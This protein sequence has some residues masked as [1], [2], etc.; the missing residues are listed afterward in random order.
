[1]IAV[2][3]A[4]FLPSMQ[5]DFLWD[6]RFFVSENP[7]LL[8]PHFLQRFLT[9]PFGG[10]S[11]LDEN[12]VQLDRAIQFY[13]PL[14]SLSN[15]IDLKIWGLNPAGFHL[16][17]I[18]IQILN[19]LLLY[20]VLFELGVGQ[21][22]SLLSALLFSVFPLHFENVSWI[23]GR[24]DLLSFLFAALSI[25]AFF[26][27]FKQRKNSVLLWSSFFYLC[28]LMAKETNLFLPVIY[29]L[30]LYRKEP[31]VKSAIR[32]V[33]PFLA[34]LLTWFIL[35][36]IAL[37]SPSL[38]YSGRTVL[39]FLAAIGFYT[40]K[41]VFPFDLSVTVEAYHI[42]NRVGFQ[43][44]GG[45]MTLAFML[46]TALILKRSTKL[47]LATFLIFAFYVL[48]LPSAAVIFSS[49]TISLMAWRFLYLLSAL[50]VSA[51]VFLA[52]T[53]INWKT[54]AIGGLG[55]LAVFY[56]LEIYPKNRLY[57]HNE[58]DFWMGI[59]DVG[60]EDIIARSNIGIKYLDR[61]ER[62]SLEIL[63]AILAEKDH[64]LHRM[65]EIRIYEELAEYYTLKRDFAK[66]EE[67]FNLLFK[68][69]RYQS[70][71]CYFNYADF[72]ALTDK[73][74][75]GE[76]IVQEMITMFPSNHL[77]LNYAVRF[78]LLVKD[79][80]KAV[81]YVKKDSALFPNKKTSRLLREIEELEKK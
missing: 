37:G 33:S 52:L 61:D 69:Q 58:T 60:R 65:W 68:L 2:N 54:A 23:S 51:L 32:L 80:P 7:S 6:D 22:V 34:G 59:K 36:R 74:Q 19:C 9:S 11:G 15:W 53:K 35:R 16:T 25:L 70:Q 66:A 45:L 40:F 14:T 30:I 17:N 47:R 55:I 49:W 42:F 38:G 77:V 41:I 50:F 72:L 39:D 24:T 12:S 26:K 48:L 79:Y 8:G 3:L 31:K 76:R 43:V 44:L 57:G 46:S 71:H 73:A 28:S 63:N 20:F 64:P 67:Y 78:Y 13:R 10:F 5:G 27:F 81:E 1:L 56:A 75:E 62:K 18:L 21:L 29:F 4:L